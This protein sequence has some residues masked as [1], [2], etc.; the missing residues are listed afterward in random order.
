MGGIIMNRSSCVRGILLVG[1]SLLTLSAAHAQSERP[2]GAENSPAIVVNNGLNPNAPAPGALD[3]GING[4]GQMISFNQVSPTGASLSLCSGTLINPRTVIFAAHCV[5]SR[6]AHQYGSQTGTGGGV[7]GNFGSIT[8]ILTTT[9]TRAPLTAQ[10]VPLSFGFGATN[11]CLATTPGVNAGTATAPNPGNG[12][13]AETG[14]YEK[15]RNSNFGTVT[16]AAIFNA[17]QIWYDTR[18]LEPNAIGFLYA[19]VAIATLD[20]PANDI[21]TWALLFTPLEGPTHGIITGYGVNGTAASAQG[22]VACTTNCSPLGGIDYRRRAAENMIDALMSLDDR[23]NFLFGPGNVDNPQTLYQTDFD[24]PAGQAAFTGAF[25]NYDFD[26]F[27]GAALPREG[28]TAGGDSGGPLI[29]DQ[30]YARPVVTAVLSGGTRFFNGQRFSTYGTNSFYQ[31]LFLYWEQIVANNP[32]VYATNKAGSR[33]WTDPTHWVQQMDPNY[34][35][36][37]NGALQ[38]GLPNFFADG[39]AGNGPRFGTVC[40]L[41]D[42]AD[43]S[44]LSTPLQTSGS[45]ILVPGGP[46]SINF[47]PN[48]VAPVNSATPGLTVKARYY[49][50]TLSA[51]GTTSATTAIEIDRLTIDGAAKLDVKNAG[52]LSVLGDFTQVTGWTNIDGRLKTGEALVVRGLLSGTGTFD[53]TFLTVVGGFVAP[54][55]G[56]RVGT[57]TVRSD[58]ILASASALFIDVQRGS[59]DKLVVTGDATSTGVLAI[60]GATLVVNK[61]GAAPRHGEAYTIASATGG[62]DGTFGSIFSF[63]GVLRP[64]LA[65]GANDIV[66]TLRAG[67]L[68]VQLGQSTASAQAFASALDTLRT[69]SYASLWNLYGAV[70]L[71]APGQL[72]ATLDGLTPRI[73]GESSLLQDRQSRMLMANVVDRLAVT[74]TGRAGGL[75]VIGDAGGFVRSLN[76]TQAT[77]QAFSGLSQSSEVAGRLPSGVTGFIA[78]GTTTGNASYGGSARLGGGRSGNWMGM[79][80]EFSAGGRTTVGTATGFATATSSPAGDRTDSRTFQVAG[81][82]THDLGGGAYLGGVGSFETAHLDADRL[83]FDGTNLL[84]L[85]GAT[86]SRRIGLIGEAGKAF[87]LGAGLTLTPRVRLAY[88]RQALAGFRER[89]GETALAVDSLTR[90][91]LEAKLGFALAGAT[92]VGNGWRFSPQVQADFARRIAGDGSTMVVRFAGAPGTGIALPLADSSRTWGEARAALRLDNGTIAF[93]AGA[94]TA[95]GAA[96]RDDRALAG[97]TMRF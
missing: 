97:F 89:G 92:P 4:V 57:L 72:G 79:G 22:A 23:D 13:Q 78:S 61:V 74:G 5:N 49:D 52:N 21:P 12:C 30:A 24:S 44:G 32:Y 60:N 73:L 65:Y 62:I 67:S 77:S 31:P 50:V 43:L 70:D 75:S 26:L 66:A 35:I 1:A 80:L 18:S 8:A 64:E 94:E 17:N 85:S 29:A 2:V 55:G 10:G 45:P 27:N 14:A 33:D 9:V 7:N 25:N 91:R 51:A 38:N 90:E 11:R 76:G 41:N 58:V 88:D 36:A 15:W 56:D 20:T 48:N 6:P 47:V 95:F 93:S 86:D 34:Q 19:D 53:P 37:V 42:C 28:T 59:A 81:Y 54:G 87:G 40:F 16:D 71:M 3:T 68:A 69:T 63:Q 39:P 82:A 83:G 96:Y 84:A 46:G